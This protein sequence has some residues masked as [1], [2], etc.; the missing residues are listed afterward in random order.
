MNVREIPLQL[1]QEFATDTPAQVPLEREHSPSAWA[2][3]APTENGL[4]LRLENA[5]HDLGHLTN[6]RLEVHLD[7][8]EARNNYSLEAIASISAG[9]RVSRQ[10]GVDME[11]AVWF[12]PALPD[13][14]R[15]LD[16]DDLPDF[17]PLLD[18]MVYRARELYADPEVERRR[19]LL[20]D[21]PEVPQLM[22]TP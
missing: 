9:E 22:L 13:R 2:Q 18:R 17:L 20:A 8:R 12:Q 19:Y 16:L 4:W 3:V 5:G 14:L 11:E 21:R 7:E 1:F 6:I 10:W 15:Y